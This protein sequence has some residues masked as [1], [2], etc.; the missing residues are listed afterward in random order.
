MFMS[1]FVVIARLTNLNINVK[2]VIGNKNIKFISIK[3]TK[4]INYL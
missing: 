4:V 3:N 2:K 1:Q